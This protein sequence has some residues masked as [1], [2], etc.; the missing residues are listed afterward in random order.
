MIALDV[1]HHTLHKVLGH[2]IIRNVTKFQNWRSDN[3]FL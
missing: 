2:Y 3:K 1:L